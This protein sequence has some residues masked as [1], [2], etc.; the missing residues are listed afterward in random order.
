MIVYLKQEKD[1][2][3]SLILAT[4][5]SEATARRIADHLALFDAVLAST[6]NHNLRGTA[7]RDAIAAHAQGPYEYMGDHAID[8][9]IWTSAA[10]AHVVLP[11]NADWHRSIPTAQRG[12]RFQALGGTWKNLLRALRL[13][14]WAKNVLI[15]LPLFL[16]HVFTD[17]AKLRAGIIAFFSFSLSASAIYLVNDIFDIHADRRHPEKRLRPFAR[18]TYAIPSGLLWSGALLV[19]SLSLAFLLSPLVALCIGGYVLITCLYTLW[20]KKIPVVDVV[21]IGFFYTYRILVGAIA[22]ETMVSDWLLVF[23]A[24]FFLSLGIEKRYGELLRVANEPALPP[25][26]WLS[27]RRSSRRLRLR[28]N[29]AFLSLLV[30]AFT[31]EAPRSPF[32]TH[33]SYFGAWS[34]S[35]Y[36]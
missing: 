20:L 30:L 8:L 24:F 14:Q 9:P 2:G 1:R 6:A 29:T 19:V 36:G 5:A 17:P 18:G 12:E 34:F 33:P 21:L 28:L 4:A 32:Y 15:F 27:Q 16:S 7:K 3:R 26:A 35:G 31:F 25:W 23:S 13:H 10:R 11:A 22:T